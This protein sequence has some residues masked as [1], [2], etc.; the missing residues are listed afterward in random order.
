ML[1]WWS[2]F[3]WVSYVLLCSLMRC[4][5]SCVVCVVWRGVLLFHYV[6]YA[7]CVSIGGVACGLCCCCVRGMSLMLLL[8]EMWCCFRDVCD[9]VVCCVVC[10]VVGVVFGLMCLVCLLLCV[11]VGCSVLCVV[12]VLC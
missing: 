4:H 12:F 8:Y 5:V 10:C 2:V 1:L 9:C 11:F 3:V 7:M 6:M